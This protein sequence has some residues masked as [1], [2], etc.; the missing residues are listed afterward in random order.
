MTKAKV[1][2]GIGIRGRVDVYL[3]DPQTGRVVK[4]VKQ[5]NKV[6]TTGFQEL[7]TRMLDPSANLW[8]LRRFPSQIAIG[9]SATAPSGV[10]TDILAPKGGAFG[11]AANSLYQSSNPDDPAGPG[12][13]TWRGFTYGIDKWERPSATQVRFTKLFPAGNA[14]DNIN[15]GAIREYGLYGP[16]GFKTGKTTTLRQLTGV[17]ATNV[18]QRRAPILMNGYKYAVAGASPPADEDELQSTMF[19]LR[20]AWVH[21]FGETDGLTGIGGFVEED[22]P[23][24]AQVPLRILSAMVVIPPFSERKFVGSGANLNYAV[25]EYNPNLAPFM[26]PNMVNDPGGV[27]VGSSGA[28]TVPSAGDDWF[29]QDHQVFHL[30]ENPG[31]LEKGFQ[32]V[33]LGA[34]GEGVFRPTNTLMA[35]VRAER[36]FKL[37]NTLGPGGSL[38]FNVGEAHMRAI[39]VPVFVIEYIAQNRHVDFVTDTIHIKPELF[40]RAV[41]PDVGKTSANQMRVTWTWDFA[42]C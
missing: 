39:H 30:K 4:H 25:V 41:L 12:L 22:I 6:T 21:A 27:P 36:D 32:I 34:N 38:D 11:T 37:H 10:E 28:G 42:N 3:E 13:I 23:V 35:Q 24:L 15:S 31:A 1:M 40:S 26:W 18:L 20:Q 14:S 33:R 5:A 16:H 29:D 9:S 17:P 8:E 7:L 2:E 19:L